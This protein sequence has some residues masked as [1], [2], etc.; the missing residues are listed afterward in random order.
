MSSCVFRR[1]FQAKGSVALR[2]FMHSQAML[3][4]TELLGASMEQTAPMNYLLG[5]AH[6]GHHLDLAR[7]MVGQELDIP[8]EITVENHWREQWQS[9]FY[10]QDRM[11][12]SRPFAEKMG[13]SQ[14]PIPN[15]LALSLA[16]SMSH[17][18]DTRDVFDLRFKKAKYLEPIYPGDTLRKKFRIENIRES[19]DKKKVIVDISCSMNNQRNIQ[20]FSLIKT[21]MFL[22]LQMSQ[23]RPSADLYSE[24]VFTPFPDFESNLA[25]TLVLRQHAFSPVTVGSP[26]KLSA[27]NLILHT[28][29]RP[30]GFSSSL[31][32][33]TAHRNTHPRLFNNARYSK[34]QILVTGPCV[35]AAASSAASRELYEV[36]YE[37]TKNA[38][39][40]NQCTPSDPIGAM[41]YIKKITS[42]GTKL[43]KVEVTTL[44]V[45]NID[46]ARDMKDLKLPA[47][48]FDQ[49]KTLLPS[50]IE[51]IC[52]E[53]CPVLRDKIVC[54]SERILIRM[55]PED[56]E[57]FL[58]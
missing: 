26:T 56:N 6:I 8:Y 42:L 21:M 2:R 36:L 34:D 47:S 29:L 30:V 11:Y 37:E 46:V 15:S 25:K 35:L 50:E 54:H 32:F 14:I 38:V 58:L 1:H 19:K 24:K 55:K 23:K 27:G 17:V 33:C 20:V 51:D 3:Q 45:K 13:M 28:F 12:T 9:T 40:V 49:K 53:H 18:D 22:K 4:E 31:N 39:C 52:E 57:V 41:T 7:V 48:L 43:D 16:S 44:G 10:Q 5:D